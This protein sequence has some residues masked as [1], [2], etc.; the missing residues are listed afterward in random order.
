MIGSTRHRSYGLTMV[1]RR[2][3][4]STQPLP[5]NAVLVRAL[6]HRYP[7]GRDF[8]RSALI[9]DAS[10]NFD[11][12]GYYGLSL[13]LAADPWPMARIL[14]EKTRR[15]AYVALFE[16][17]AFAERDLQLVASGRE[18]HFDATDGHFLLGNSGSVRITAGSAEQLADRF[19][20]AP[21]TVKR[22]PFYERDQ[23]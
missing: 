2:S 22:N 3:I 11:E 7:D 14:K 18:P 16:A 17:A 8:D 15:A 13:W 5:G 6:F 4:R 20:D 10:Y 21:Y 9:A 23:R 1:R 19:L 12:F